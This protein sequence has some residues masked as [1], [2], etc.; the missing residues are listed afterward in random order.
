MIE[1]AFLND[2]ADRLLNN[3][4]AIETCVA[5]LTPEQIWWRHSEK[6]NAIGNLILHLAG[7]VRQQI[8]ATLAGEPDIRVRVEEF[9]ARGEK[10]VDE[11]RALLRS[12]VEQAAEV[13]RNYPEA[14]LTEQV[15]PPGR[16]PSSA[17]A[18]ITHVV[19][20]FTGH[21]Y[22]IIYAT[23]MQTTEQFSIF[24]A[25]QTGR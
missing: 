11:M 19:T 5:K 23:K 17:F 1:K 25:A 12:R 16:P 13:I 6:E 3:M 22:Q 4:K 8:I 2:S 15:T 18:L 7:N 20:H 10:A 9:S 21:T 24:A 14:Q